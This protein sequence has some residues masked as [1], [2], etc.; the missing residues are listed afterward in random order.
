MLKWI[1]AFA[2]LALAGG[3]VYFFVIAPVG[4]DTRANAVL[5]GDAH[6]VSDEAQ[7]LHDSIA[8]ADLHADTLLWMRDPLKRQQRGQTDVPR[9]LEG[10]VRLQVFTAVTK[11]PRGQNYERNE[12]DTDQLTLLLQAQRWPL[13]TWGSLY[14]R[15][16][17]QGARL[18]RLAQDSGGDLILVRTTRDLE[19]ALASDVLGGVF[20]IEGAHALEGDL[21]NLDRL[22]DAGLRLVGLHHFFDNELGGSLH[23]LSRDGLTPFGRAVVEK[24]AGKR[25]IIDVAHSSEQ[26]VLEVLA[27][28]DRPDIVSHTGLKGHCDSPRNISDEV[29]KAVADDGGLVGVG[30]WDGAVCDPAPASVAAAIVY[31][32]DLLGTEHVALG[33]DFDGTVTTAFD[34]SELAVLTQALMDAGL[35]EATI[36]AVMGGNAIRFFMEHLPPQ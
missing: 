27:L 22:Y 8:V 23:G 5:E 29:M 18:E 2:A 6:L 14:E 1:G 11:S 4:F 15:A 9:L 3:A 20:G 31:A 30:F 16:L 12:A 28:T 13:R 32:I 33:S 24:A 19:R 36:R 35:D 26:T 10:G 34:A 25:M 7:A 21:D 17:Y